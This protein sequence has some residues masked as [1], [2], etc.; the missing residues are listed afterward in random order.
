MSPTIAWPTTGRLGSRMSKVV[1]VA[2]TAFFALAC[3]AVNAADSACDRACLIGV[4]DT[5]LAAIAAHDPS[6]APLSEH[7]AFV[8]NIKKTPVGKG[9]GPQRPGRRRRS[10]STC[11]IPS[12]ARSGS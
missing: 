11:R 2:S 5:Y 12:R 3:A 9:S 8:E 1:N 10:R 4:A 7:V 6:K